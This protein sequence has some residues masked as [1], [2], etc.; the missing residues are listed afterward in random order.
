MATGIT[1][2]HSVNGEPTFAR[3]D[4]RKYGKQLAAFFASNN[5]KIEDKKELSAKLKESIAQAERGDVKKMDMNN[6]WD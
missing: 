3:I 5:V 4:L 1:I 6:I 2:E